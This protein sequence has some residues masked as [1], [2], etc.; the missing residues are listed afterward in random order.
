MRLMGGRRIIRM[1]CRLFK[2]RLFLTLKRWLPTSKWRHLRLFW[3]D[4]M[5]IGGIGRIIVDSNSLI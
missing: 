5:R 4:V 2:I 3:L 1:A